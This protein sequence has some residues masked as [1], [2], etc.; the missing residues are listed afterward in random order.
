[1]FL[2]KKKT[3]LNNI[4][5]DY[6]EF[7]SWLLELG[8]FRTLQKLVFISTHILNITIE[9]NSSYKNCRNSSGVQLYNCARGT[10]LKGEG[11][12]LVWG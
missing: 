5:P 8:P 11:W 9:K 12:G 10:T 4:V 7:W 2:E 6:G 3:T 1:M